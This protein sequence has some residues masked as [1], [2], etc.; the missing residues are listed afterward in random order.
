MCP[1]LKFFAP[2]MRRSFSSRKLDFYKGSLVCG[3]LSNSVSQRLLN[4]RGRAKAIS[5]VSAGSAT[6]TKVY[7]SI[8]QCLGRS[9]SASVP[10]YMVPDPR[11][12]IKALLSVGRCQTFVVE[13]GDRNEGYLT[14]PWCW[15]HS[16]S[17]VFIGGW[18]H[19]DFLPAK[20][21]MIS[22]ILDSQKHG[23][24]ILSIT[25]FTQSRKTGIAEFSAQGT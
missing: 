1:D 21:A 24:C 20:P 8:A 4:H 10:W 2:A 14:P 12:S 19:W 17:R 11:G 22:K 16:K 25:L 15:C 13:L 3:W 18:W 5:K 9:V 6:R 7:L 23:R